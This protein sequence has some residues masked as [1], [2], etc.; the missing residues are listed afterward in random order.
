MATGAGRNGILLGPSMGR[1][2]ADLITKGTTDIPIDAFD[3]ARF[4][5]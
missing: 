2:T 3:A 1:V 4:N 5:A